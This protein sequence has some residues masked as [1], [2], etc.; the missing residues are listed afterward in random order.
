MYYDDLK[1]NEVNYNFLRK[2]LKNKDIWIDRTEFN[3]LLHAINFLANT[4]VSKEVAIK[5]VSEKYDIATAFILEHI[6]AMEYLSK[7]EIK[8]NNQS[9]ESWISDK[10]ISNYS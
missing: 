7:E 1:Y 8:S 9:W 2:Y 6:N 10:I 5:F 4:N 3:C